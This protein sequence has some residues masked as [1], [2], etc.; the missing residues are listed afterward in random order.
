MYFRISLMAIINFTNSIMEVTVFP[1]VRHAYQL[2]FSRNVKMVR[3]RNFYESMFI[4]FFRNLR[5]PENQ[6]RMIIPNRWLLLNNNNNTRQQQQ[7]QQQNNKTTTKKLTGNNSNNNNP[8]KTRN[9]F[10]GDFLMRLIPKSGL[11]SERCFCDTLSYFCHHHCK[12]LL[13]HP[14]SACVYVFV[15]HF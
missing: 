15:V 9:K 5:T 1:E 13:P 12:V 11:S 8:I 4:D 7:Q 3:K 2:W 6:G 14:V 10:K